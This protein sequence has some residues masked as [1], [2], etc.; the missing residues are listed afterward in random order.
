MKRKQ[1]SPKPTKYGG[2]EIEV[3]IFLDF[4]RALSPEHPPEYVSGSPYG[5]YKSTEA[6]PEIGK[7]DHEI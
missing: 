5:K 6:D 1:K 3:R 7:W 4:I 2:G